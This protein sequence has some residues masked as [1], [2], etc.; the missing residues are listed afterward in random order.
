MKKIA[1]ML[2]I[3][4]MTLTAV[5][6]GGGSDPSSGSSD[7]G[8]QSS[9]DEKGYTFTYNDV[10]IYIDEDAAA[11]ID[12]LGDYK[13]YSESATCAFEGMDKQYFYGSF[14]VTTGTLDAREFISG[15]WFVDDTVETDEGLCIGDDEDKVKQLYGEDGYNGS[16]AYIYTKGLCELTIIVEDGSVS[17]VLYSYKS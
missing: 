3:C 17:S 15:F 14:Y 7:Q 5:G 16:N 2:M 9:S 12:G 11:V 6:C 1:L 4:M 13:D 10:E 8:G